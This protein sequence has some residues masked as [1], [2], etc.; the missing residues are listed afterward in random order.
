RAEAEEIVVSVSSNAT[1]VAAHA[2]RRG[3]QLAGAAGIPLS[4]LREDHPLGNIGCAGRLAGRAEAVIVVY[5]DNLTTL[6][7]RALLLHHFEQGAA[8]TI[9]THTEA[10]RLPYGRTVVQDGEVVDYVEKPGIDV[11]I[12]SGLA[13]L[14]EAALELLAD[15]RPTG[16]VDLFHMVRGAGH[17]VGA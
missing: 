15:A 14:G 12:C 8:M 4:L 16:M 1:D 6:D 11:V 2:M 13:V 17:R 10:F 3:A 5:V 7:L 9:A